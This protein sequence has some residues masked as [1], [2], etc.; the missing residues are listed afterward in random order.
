M[1]FDGDYIMKKT[2]ILKKETVQPK[3]VYDEHG[4]KVGVIL[5]RKVYEKLMDVVNDYH[6]Y[7]VVQKLQKKKRS[8]K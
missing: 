3:Y 4:K 2:P 8:T 6:D 7:K 5:E 1:I